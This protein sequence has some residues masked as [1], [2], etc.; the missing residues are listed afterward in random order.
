MHYFLNI[1][2]NLGNRRLNLSRAVAALERE[3][4]Y[5]EISKTVESKPWGFDSTNL[6]LNAAMMVITDLQPVEVLRKIKEIERNIYP[7][8]HRTPS[9]NYAD[10]VIDID[11]MGADDITV[12]TPE[13]KI[14]HPRLAERRFFLEPFAELAPMWRHPVT[15]LTPGEML[16]RLAEG[17]KE[18]R[19]DAIGNTTP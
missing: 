9:G 17:D 13:L 10:R 2:S 15:G 3:F 8:S 14:P 4:G 19:P 1:G 11:I 18:A 12:D 6:F 16:A 7:A 5:F